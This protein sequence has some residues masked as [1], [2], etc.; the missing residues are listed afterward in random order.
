MKMRHFAFAAGATALLCGFVTVGPLTPVASAQESPDH[1]RG[2]AVFSHWCAPCHAAGPGH[3]GTQGLEMKYRGSGVPA[4]LEE[5]DDLTPELVKVFVRQGVL[6]MAPF[7][8]T[9]VTDAELE[10]LAAYLSK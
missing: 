10:D 2:Q 8:K 4:E 6:S 3:P 9:E 5:R 7:R 1:E